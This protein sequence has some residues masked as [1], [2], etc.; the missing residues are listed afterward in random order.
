M[1]LV[2]LP[3]AID[4]EGMVGESPDFSRNKDGT[5]SILLIM[6]LIGRKKKETGKVFS[7]RCQPSK[8]KNSTLR[9]KK[10]YFVKN[11]EGEGANC[12]AANLSLKKKYY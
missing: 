5:I 7:Q 12:I 9:G 10:Q 6:P 8:T 4:G 3:T 11:N 1:Y 2:F